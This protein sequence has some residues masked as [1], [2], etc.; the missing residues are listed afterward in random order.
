MDDTIIAATMRRIRRR[1][2]RAEIRDW[3]LVGVW[4]TLLVAVLVIGGRHVVQAADPTC[5]EAA[6]E[7]S[8]ATPVRCDYRQGA[9]WP[10]SDPLRLPPCD[11]DAPGHPV[12]GM[13]WL[14][15]DGTVSIWPRPYAD[16]P[17]EILE[18]SQ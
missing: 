15:D 16:Q 2:R 6:T 18:P 14:A 3:L 5:W 13:C 8:V 1:E 12:T 17:L 11:D 10:V 4:L 7:D 9:F